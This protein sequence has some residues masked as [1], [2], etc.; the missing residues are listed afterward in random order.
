MKTS[1]AINYYGNASK[2]AD[3]LDVSKQAISQWGDEV[4]RLRAFELQALTN[5]ALKVDEPKEESSNQAA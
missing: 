5:G 3:A 1:T 4:P 2:L